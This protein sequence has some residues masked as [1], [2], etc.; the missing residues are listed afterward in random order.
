MANVTITN[1]TT[2][3][4]FADGEVDSVEFR[5]NGSLD[6]NS[7]PAS[8]SYDA[9]VL[10]FQGVKKD[11]VVV[12]K[13]FDTTGSSRTDIGTT[14]TIEDQLNWLAGILNGSQTGVTFSSSYQTNKKLYMRSC[15]FT[16]ISGNPLVVVFRLEFVEGM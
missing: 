14:V 15:T 5:K 16:E 7:M 9:F 11:V 13:L 2:T 8:D 6:E 3:F 10:D 4:T 1:G 12:G